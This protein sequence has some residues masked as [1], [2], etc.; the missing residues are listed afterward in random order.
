MAGAVTLEQVEALAAQLSPPEQLKLLVRISERLS[1]STPPALA[2]ES[3]EEW[4][5]QERLRLAEELLREVE[6]MEDDSQ[7][8]FDAAEAI[9]RMREERTAQICR[10]DA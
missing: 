1:T 9:G 10:S 5:Q 4:L 2:E 6:G 3:R 7:G 8:E